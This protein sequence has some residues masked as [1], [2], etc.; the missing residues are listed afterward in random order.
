MNSFWLLLSFARQF[1]STCSLMCCLLLSALLLSCAIKL[2]FDYPLF[3]FLLFHQIAT[4]WANVPVTALPWDRGWLHCECE[5]K[6]KERDCFQIAQAPKKR[7]FFHFLPGPQE[8]KKQKKS[9]RQTPLTKGMRGNCWAQCKEVKFSLGACLEGWAG[10]WKVSQRKIVNKE[11]EKRPKKR[12]KQLK[13]KK[14]GWMR[15]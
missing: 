7:H 5:E 3:C 10:A 14:K 13:K 8:K 11:K 4:A 12:Q 1:G 15:R 9:R 6:R 2:S